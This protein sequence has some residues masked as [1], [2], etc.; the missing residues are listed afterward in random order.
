MP[1]AHPGTKGLARWTTSLWWEVMA[2]A[3]L[4]LGRATRTCG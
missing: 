2:A 1:R 3:S 4:R